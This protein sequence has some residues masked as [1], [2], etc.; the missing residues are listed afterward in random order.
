MWVWPSREISNSFSAKILSSPIRICLSERF[1]SISLVELHKQFV[2]SPFPPSRHINATLRLVHC[3]AHLSCRW[4]IDQIDVGL[5]R[6][7][8]HKLIRFA[9][10]YRAGMHPFI[11]SPFAGSF[12]PSHNP[13]NTKGESSFMLIEYGI[14]PPGPFHS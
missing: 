11:H 1:V 10:D 12:Q 6:V 3:C 2:T 14:L 5:E 8:P 4:T 7:F 9:G 13:A